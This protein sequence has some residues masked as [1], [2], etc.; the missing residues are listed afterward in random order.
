VTARALCDKRDPLARRK[1]RHVPPGSRSSAL[2][3]MSARAA[4]GRFVLQACS[5][6]GVIT[7]PP[8]DAC[9]RCWGSLV[10]NDQAR[11]AELL[12]ET[13]IRTT[14]DLYFRDHLPWRMGKLALDAGPVALAH[15]HADLRVGDRADMQLVI[16][17][18]GNAALFAGP[19]G[20]NADMHD[21]QWREFMIPV[22]DR[23]ILVSDARSALGRA[24][25]GAL[26]AAG[27]RLV[28]AGMAPPAR[29]A[30]LADELL[31][32]DGIQPVP[33]DLTDPVSIAEGLSK[34]GG[35]LDIVINSARFVRSGGVSHGGN[36]TDQRRA[37]ELS[38]MG[39]SRLAQACA[40]MLAGRAS[41]AFVDIVSA[42]ALAPDAD[43]AAHSAVEAARHSLVQ[44]FRHEMRNAGVR[45]L[46]VLTGP[47]D[48]EDHQSIPPPKVAPTRIAQGILAALAR[49]IEQ[50][51]VGDVATDALTRWMADP[52]LY[53]REKNL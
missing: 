28:V 31:A 53:T 26:H 10:W 6:C 47:T 35:P 24:I 30:D 41:S 44:S 25:V 16:D 17:K 14:T 5:D 49:G 42:H 32:Q 33:L 52:A 12:S 4:T 50:S 23:T 9:P 48:D 1:D 7:Y 15:L 45:V 20:R 51:C 46:S 27:A 3:A 8:R 38:V 40:P 21:R 39:F 13:V 2:H 43:F 34:I 19:A 18:G 22:K 11:G 29:T 36:L 37:F